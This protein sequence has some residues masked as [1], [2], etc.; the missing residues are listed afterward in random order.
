MHISAFLSVTFLPAYCLSVCPFLEPLNSSLRGKKEIKG[1]KSQS[2][3]H[4]LTGP[5]IRKTWMHH[6]KELNIF[7]K[8]LLAC[9]SPKN[10][11]EAVCGK[12]SANKHENVRQRGFKTSG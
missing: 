2:K 7:E 11:L 8:N 10:K 12:L 5:Y 9:I 1:V 6:C 3:I 4:R